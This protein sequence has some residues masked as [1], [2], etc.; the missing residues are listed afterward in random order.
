MSARIDAVPAASGRDWP[1]VGALVVLVAAFG[2]VAGPIG[3]LAGLATALVGVVL[4]PPYALAAGH[5]ALVVAVPAG[6]PLFTV[7]A[8]EAAF[9]LVALVSLRRAASPGRVALVASTAALA[10][11][12]VAWLALGTGS[13]ALAAATTIAC[14]GLAGYGLHRLALVR[15]G[16]VP[17]SDGGAA[18]T[19]TEPEPATETEPA[20]RSPTDQ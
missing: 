18:S 11:G 13:I 10:L 4:G 20:I 6:G 14:L 19:A 3:L 8:V 15:L 5:V 16:L 7:A 12:G 17:G 2:V 9:V 1:T